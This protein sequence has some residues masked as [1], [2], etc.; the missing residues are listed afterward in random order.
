MATKFFEAA[1][2]RGRIGPTLKSIL[3]IVACVGVCAVLALG[4]AM[5]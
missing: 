4:Y 5:V 1:R 3:T 2:G